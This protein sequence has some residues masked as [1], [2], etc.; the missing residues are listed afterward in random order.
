ML[1]GH[2]SINIKLVEFFADA[3]ELDFKLFG[4]NAGSLKLNRFNYRCLTQIFK[5]FLLFR[6]RRLEEFHF[7]GINLGKIIIASYIRSTRDFELL[8][9]TLQNKVMVIKLAFNSICSV[10][11]AE[12]EFKKRRI[13]EILVH[14]KGYT[15]SAE[16]V[17]VGI[18]HGIYPI[19]VV[20]AHKNNALMIRRNDKNNI[21]EHPASISRDLFCKLKSNSEDKSYLNVQAD[22]QKCYVNGEWYSE[23]GTVESIKPSENIEIKN[24]GE[25]KAVAGIFPHI[26]F[27]ATFFY[28]EDLFENYF[29]WF[30]ALV[31]YAE[32]K[33]EILWI[34]KSHPANRIK[35]IRD[36]VTTKKEKDLVSEI[37]GYAP[38]NFLFLDTDTNLSSQDILD[39]CNYVFTVRG[40]IGLEGAMKGKIVFTAGTGRYDGF[41]FTV[42]AQSIDQYFQQIEDIITNKSKFE[43]DVSSA[44]R[45]ADCVF[46]K[47]VF[48]LTGFSWEYKKENAFLV[49]S[50]I[51]NQKNYQNDVHR[52][53]KFLSS[54]E[55]EYMK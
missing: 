11:N 31:Q 21:N 6:G 9:G 13:T 45:F 23:V 7:Q 29:E 1:Y 32:Q 44:L 18:K 49:D 43:V 22:I 55:R 47:R 48:E 54:F 33:K 46:Q 38:S 27:D 51:N 50:K 42:D 12:E 10:L 16:I 24:I 53:S 26:F 36:G 8:F 37:L 52:L 20:A 4:A 40:T 15:P 35:D 28:G 5:V 41:G 19:E 2:D 14:D 17:H 34:I 30:K 3:L 25:Y 39:V